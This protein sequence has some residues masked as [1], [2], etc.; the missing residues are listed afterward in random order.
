MIFIPW[1]LI[2]DL[3]T[4]KSI[5]TFFILHIIASAIEL[6]SLIPFAKAYTEGPDPEIPKPKAPASITDF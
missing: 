5:P 6:A 1:L 4:S 3:C 2:D